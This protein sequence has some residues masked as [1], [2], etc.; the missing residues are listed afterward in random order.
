VSIGR[1]IRPAAIVTLAVALTGCPKSEPPAPPAGPFTLDDPALVAR[2]NRGVGQMGRFEYDAARETFAALVAEHPNWLDARVNLAISTFNRQQDGDEQAG[3]ELLEA[4]LADDPDHLRAHYCAGLLKNRGGR[5]EEALAHFRFVTEADPGDPY[6]A[7]SVA[8]CVEPTSP[9]EAL[10]LYLRVV[11]IDPYLRSAYYRVFQLLQRLGRTDEAQ[12]YFED[13][14]RLEKN[15]Q[16]RLIKLQYTRMGPKADALAVDLAAPAPLPARPSGPVFAD[17]VP[18]L[19]DPGSIAWNDT[20]EHT[21]SISAADANGDGILDVFIAGALRG[22]GALNAVC[23]GREDGSFVL[24]PDHALARVPDVRAAAWG[25]FDNDGLTDVYLC[26]HG[27][28]ALYR[29]TSP[30]TW[31]NVTTSTG[32][33]G[34][35]YH[36]VD[37]R[38][39]DAD[40]DGDLDIFCV[41]ADG[42]NALLGNN[43]DG[44]FR[45]LTGA[46]A[47]GT[48][49]AGDGRPSRQ[50]LPADLDGDR[51]LDL[52]V[53]NVEPPHDAYR[54]DRLWRYAPWSA[55]FVDRPIVRAVAADV[56][57]DGAVEL[58]ALQ[59]DGAVSVHA[60]DAPEPVGTFAPA[61]PEP[62]DTRRQIAAVDVTGNGRPEL[63]RSTPAGWSV[64]DASTGTV[65][66]AS[67]HDGLAGWAP[68]VLDAGR[69]PSVV[70]WAPGA[71]PVV[72]RPG[73]GRHAFASFTFS[74]RTEKGDAMRSNASGFG[75]RAAFRV[76]S[77]WSVAHTL[78]ATSGPGQ[79]EQPLAVGL[80]GAA[81]V[82][83]VAVDWSDGVFQ[84]EIDLAAGARHDLV[85]EQRQISSCPVLFAWNGTDYAFVSDV[86]GVGGM[87]YL[88]EPGTYATPRPWEHFLM[89][90][91]ALAPRDGR[92]AIKLAEPMEEA[93]YLDA[94][95]LVVHDLPPGWSMTIDERMS[96]LGPEPTGAPRYYRR[97][98]LPVRAVNDRGDD[99]TTQ[100]TT[101]DFVAAPVGALDRRFLG[102]LERDHALTLEFDAP[103]AAGDGAPMLVI[104][105]WVEYP[106]SQTMFAAWQAKA[107]YRAPTLEARDADGVWHVVLEQFGYPA[108]MPRQMSVP[109]DGLPADADALRLVTNQEIYWDRVAVAYAEPCPDARRTPLTLAS[110]RVD[111]TGFARRTTGPQRLPH[112]DYGDRA[113][114]WDTRHQRGMYTALGPMT[115]LVAA[116]D[117][118]LAII[119]PGEE[120]HA[121]FDA[122]APPAAGWTRRH[123]LVTHGWCKDMDLFTRDG[124]TVA[125]LPGSAT[126]SDHRSAAHRRYNTRYESGR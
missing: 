50:V 27:R 45:G 11:E 71:G 35:L 106:Y 104:D 4:V 2:N 26:R 81:R 86:L 19:V 34:G 109:L 107:A 52:V 103:I 17:A 91:D 18:L 101:M 32:T 108:G 112:Y 93:L 78:G 28:N 89:P 120:V 41:N 56:D 85:E 24:A 72:W 63:I 7:Y 66:H 80:G 47:I 49:V 57:A 14:Q 36:T 54:N 99:V 92:Y 69:G 29:Q 126:P 3:L 113:P 77:E 37:G 20:I 122:S 40:H 111:R 74:G 25:D 62:V 79:S 90:P 97:E 53:I 51:D 12:A 21:A 96:I 73:P 70:G 82:D 5:A 58:Y 1:V 119:G 125:P 88:V 31:E 95:S 100:V 121:E 46:D 8:Q 123:E 44:T 65:V 83:F 110:A 55:A 84:S 67:T 22:G 76:G 39:L 60:P 61:T 15:P 38:F 30:G 98:R 105:G 6:A 68:V 117:E 116:A 48:A 102:R 118:A 10:E 115:E 16:A 33:G 43:L 114:F 87:G 42:P 9:E 23:L 59:P 13:F 94:V 124:E 75:A 64:M